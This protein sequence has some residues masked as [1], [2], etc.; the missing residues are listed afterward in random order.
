MKKIVLFVLLSV[1]ASVSFSQVEE[2][3]GKKYLL[4]DAISN[5]GCV[6]FD[7]GDSVSSDAIIGWDLSGKTY[8]FNTFDI[9]QLFHAN[10]SLQI[11]GVAG[12]ICVKQKAL[13]VNNYIGIADTSFNILEEQVLSDVLIKNGNIYP[14]YELIFDNPVK[15]IGD[16][17]VI[18]DFARPHIY[19]KD[20]EMYYDSLYAAKYNWNVPM[21]YFTLMD[22]QI[23][24][25]LI[26]SDKRCNPQSIM[27]SATFFRLIVTEDVP[28]STF[29]T[30]WKDF[31][32]VDTTGLDSNYAQSLLDYYATIEGV[33]MFP[34]IGEDDDDTVSSAVSI[35][36]ENYTYVFPNPA[37]ENIMVQS[38]F[39]I[40]GIEIFN[41]QGQKIL[42]TNPNA[43]N[44]SIDVSS[45][46]KGTY[47]VKIITKSG[48]ASKKIIVQ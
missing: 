39:K 17:F 9:A 22:D 41:E 24:I 32:Y 15:V 38:S 7:C 20:G 4:P 10:D 11:I 44:T 12:Y 45:Y 37:S 29:Q 27:T 19:E 5:Q 21:N 33:Y 43:Y 28:Y 34:L 2:H 46:P 31:R 40:H 47:I 14:Y 13:I 23:I 8:M 48:T 36:V 18:T 35:E 1:F 16:F 42:T 3:N 30:D 25:P 6:E 26:K